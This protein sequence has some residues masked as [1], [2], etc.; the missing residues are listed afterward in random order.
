VHFKQDADV[1]TSDGREAGR[2]DRV[3][4]DPS[5]GAITHL[6]VKKG[7]LLTRDKVVPVDQVDTTTND[8]VLLKKNADK[9]EEFPDFEETE[10]IPVGGLEDFGQRESEQARRVIWYHTRTG[11]PWW[12]PDPYPGH[13]KPLFT[14][15][16]ERNIPE[17][18]VSLEEGAKVVD[19]KGASVG[20]V[21]DVYAEPVEHRLTHVLVSTGT[22]SKKKKLI[23]T[24]WVKDIFEESVRLSVDKKVIENLPNAASQPEGG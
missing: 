19:A 24:V 10:H 17:G 7:L 14:K 20:Q 6:V 1:L 15:K 5:T 8:Q 11:V 21:E 13:R 16:A 2:I 22:F 9:V 12:R 18:S 3:V 23:P 4:V